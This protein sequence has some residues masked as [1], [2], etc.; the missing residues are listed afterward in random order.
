M[1]SMSL[2]SVFCWLLFSVDDYGFLHLFARR[3]EVCHS[4]LRVGFRSAVLGVCYL[5]YFV[6]LRN[7]RFLLDLLDVFVGLFFAGVPDFSVCVSV[8]SGEL[9]PFCVFCRDDSC[10]RLCYNPGDLVLAWYLFHCFV[11]CCLPV[12]RVSRGM[13]VGC[14]GSSFLFPGGSPLLLSRSLSLPGFRP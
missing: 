14:L 9:H 2:W 12:C 11:G 3:V 13:V 10:C 4:G 6:L 7:F 5:V 1:V 8:P